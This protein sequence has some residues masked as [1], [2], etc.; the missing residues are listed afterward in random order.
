IMKKFTSI[1][2]FT[3]LALAI[4]SCKKDDTVAQIPAVAANGN[5]TWTTNG[6]TTV[7]TAD[8]AFY[9]SQ[10]KTIFAYKNISGLMKLQYEINLTA[11]TPA[12][13]TIGSGNAIAYTANT[14]FFIPTAGNVIITAN[15]GTKV[16]GTFTGTGTL[17]A[18]TS[19]VAGTFTDIPVQ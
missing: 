15:T 10:F 8:S 5:F 7:N 6:T 9:R 3:I 14:P 13:Y 1:L 4:I 16:T 17:T 19:S 18:G 2:A 12:T 11:G